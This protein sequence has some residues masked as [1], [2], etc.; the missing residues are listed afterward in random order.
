ME[1]GDLVPS[2]VAFNLIK[3]SMENH[4]AI[5]TTKGFLIDSCPRKINEGILFERELSC[6]S[7]LYFEASLDT[8]IERIRRRADISGRADDNED[9]IKMRLKI[10]I[11]QS[12]IALQFFEPKVKTVSYRIFIRFNVIF[13]LGV[14]FF[15]IKCQPYIKVQ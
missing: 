2:E 4:I 13:F 7:I 14:L 3:E 8:M 1:S 6:T 15:P 12:K 9:S 11:E 10:F 5:A